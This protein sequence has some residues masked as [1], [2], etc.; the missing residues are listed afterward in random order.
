VKRVALLVALFAVFGGLAATH[1][2]RASARERDRDCDDFKTQSAAQHFFVSHGGSRR[3]NFDDLDEDGDGI[4]CE[5]NPCPCS[6][7][8][9]RHHRDAE[10]NATTVPPGRRLKAHITRVTSTATP[11][12]PATP[13]APKATSG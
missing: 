10:G 2:G 12:M 13:T 7:A 3:N 6:K 4:A 1:G 9:G 11:S 5:S 8:A